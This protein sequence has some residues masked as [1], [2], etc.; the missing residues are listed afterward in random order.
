M[1]QLKNKDNHNITKVFY[2]FLQSINSG[3]WDSID[4][5]IKKIN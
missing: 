4:I 5:F 2:V 1:I 3:S